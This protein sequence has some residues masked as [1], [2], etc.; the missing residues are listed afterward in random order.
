MPKH[1]NLGQI[2]VPV[3]TYTKDG[4][5]KHRFR[6]IGTLMSTLDDAPGSKL[7]YWIKVNADCFH[8]SLFSLVYRAGMEPGDDQAVCTVFEPKPPAIAPGEYAS[9]RDLT[10]PPDD[11]IP[12]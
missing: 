1:T 9:T 11:E 3:G 2:A 7:R 6:N 8:A 4:D 12:F 10:G 5:E